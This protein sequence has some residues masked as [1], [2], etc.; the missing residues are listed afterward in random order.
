M[1]LI[2]ECTIPVLDLNQVKAFLAVADCGSFSRAAQALHSTQP[3]VSQQVRKLEAELGTRLLLRSHAKT[4]PSTDGRRFLPFARALVRTE[5]RAKNSISKS[6]LSIAASSNIGTYLLPKLL[7]EYAD[8]H[9]EDAIELL[10]GTNPETIARL[11]SGVAD[12]ALTEWWDNRS[13]FEGRVWKSEPL[14]VIVNPK[15]PWRDKKAIEKSELLDQPLIGGEPGTGTGH[16]LRQVFGQSIKRLKMELTVGSTAAVK[17]AVKADLGVSI[18][19]AASVQEELENQL[20]HAVSITDANLVKDVY[21]VIAIDQLEGSSS[22]N[23][24]QYL[25]SNAVI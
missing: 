24:C 10:Y 3:V 9:T 12:V 1:S 22:I 5:S 8:T 23:F 11:E 16:L 20:L 18:V 4:V 6:E 7:K 17:E 14:V 21:A 25:S 15:H 2:R 19:M 13:G